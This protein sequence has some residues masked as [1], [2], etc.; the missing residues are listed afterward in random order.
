[1]SS[2]LLLQK[3]SACL[4]RLTWIV[5]MMGGKWPYSWC[6]AGCCHQDL[7]FNC[8]KNFYFKLFSLIKQFSLALVYR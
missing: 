7:R 5:L 6:L 1:M 8:Q 3:C 4:V 2:F